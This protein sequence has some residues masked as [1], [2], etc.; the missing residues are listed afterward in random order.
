MEPSTSGAL[1]VRGLR[2]EE[3]EEIVS[4]GHLAAGCRQNREHGGREKGGIRLR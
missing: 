2:L 1:E 3:R 4:S